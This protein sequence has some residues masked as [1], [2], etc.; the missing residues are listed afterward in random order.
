MTAAVSRTVQLP[1]RPSSTSTFRTQPIT[2]TPIHPPQPTVASLLALS[3]TLPTPSL[4]RSSHLLT[5]AKADD[6]S[7]VSRLVG[8]T[9]LPASHPLHVNVNE[10]DEYGMTALHYAALNGSAEMCDEL[11][12]H[13][14]NPNQRDR[15]GQSPL[16][17]AS[18]KC[19][20][21]AIQQLLAHKASIA[22][23]PPTGVTPLH[24]IAGCPHPHQ[25]LC[26]DS[27]LAVRQRL[28]VQTAVDGETAL[29]A[30]VRSG[31]LAFIHWL[32]AHGANPNT[33]NR[34]GLTP[35]ALASADS[36]I[37]DELLSWGAVGGRVV[38]A[39]ARRR[40]ELK[41]TERRR[42]VEE[43]AARE[44][45]NMA[46]EEERRRVSEVLLKYGQAEVKEGLDG[47]KWAA[48]EQLAAKGKSTEAEAE[49]EVKEQ[50]E[51]A[52]EEEE[53]GGEVVLEEEDDEEARRVYREKMYT[54]WAARQTAD[55][56]E[57]KN[58]W[59]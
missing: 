23:L 44:A 9:V 8:S 30:A 26:G 15:Y 14:A 40:G 50:A 45:A 16:L 7:A 13:G 20:Y 10:A 48:D 19:H 21:L 47:G 4:T 43:R 42:V 12:T 5:A 52:E 38:S 3:S 27:L 57:V 33:P 46:A 59:Q 18:S 51:A 37:E 39:E 29:H 17:L 11:L 25:L 24:R 36:L 1:S 41:A 31:S 56:P 32:L 35:L 53:E 28:D 58:A 6:L 34:A 49:E 55:T 2:S 54:M 22:V